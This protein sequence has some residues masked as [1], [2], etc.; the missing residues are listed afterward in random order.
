[1]VWGAPGA[2]RE[3]GW[4]VLLHKPRRQSGRV[5]GG[6]NPPHV[7]SS[8][9][10]QPDPPE[11]PAF[12]HLRVLEFSVVD[13]LVRIPDPHRPRGQAGPAGGG[14]DRPRQPV[15]PDQILQGGARQGRQ[16]GGR[17]RRLAR[18]RRRP[19]QAAPRAAAGAQPAR[20]PQSVRAAHAGLSR[21]PVQGPRRDPP[22]MAAGPRRPD[23]AVRRPRGRRGAGAGG[24]QRRL[25]AG[26][27][28]PMGPYVPGQLLH[29]AAARRARRRRGLRAGRHAPGRRGGP[30]RGRHAPGAVP[31]PRRVPGPRGARLHRRGRGAGQPAPRAPIHARAIPAK[32]GRNGQALRRRALGPRQHRR[33]RA[34][35]QPDA[36][37]GQAAPARLSHARGRVARRLP[38]AALRG[39][40]GE[41]WP[42]CSRT[43]PSAPPS[44]SPTTSA[45]A[46]SARPSS[47]W[48]SP[49][50][51]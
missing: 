4:L 19:R 30:A 36:G 45:C 46:G 7:R 29:R 25:G 13:G 11:I 33:D 32:L 22:R 24:G 34:P 43:R 3:E 38:G 37:A 17:Q 41:A 5:S 47:R 20:L 2:H 39:R 18:Q 44:A 49:A 26:A 48:A 14:S 9:H 28:A 35:L 42:S 12:V 8:P 21:Q 16:A 10:L 23:R 50:T 51:S 1:M 31:R 27:G 6:Y 40:P 15:R